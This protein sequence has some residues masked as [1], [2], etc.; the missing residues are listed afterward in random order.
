MRGSGHGVLEGTLSSRGED[1]TIAVLM[2]DVD[3]FSDYSDRNGHPYGDE[4]RQTLVGT[5]R[6]TCLRFDPTWLAPISA[7]IVASSEQARTTSHD[8]PTSP[9]TWRVGGG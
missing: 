5:F 6:W 4:A 8:S 2:L 3:R 9:A 1:E 7:K